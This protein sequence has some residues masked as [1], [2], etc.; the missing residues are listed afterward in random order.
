MKS[1]QNVPLTINA[2]PLTSVLARPRFLQTGY[3]EL[4]RKEVAVTC[5]PYG[6]TSAHNIDYN[7]DHDGDDSS[8]SRLILCDAVSSRSLCIFRGHLTL[9]FSFFIVP[10]WM[11]SI[12]ST[13]HTSAI[14][15]Y[16]P[17]NPCRQTKQ[18]HVGAP[19]ELKAHLKF[20]PLSEPGWLRVVTNRT[21]RV[22][23]PFVSGFHLPCPDNG[24]LRNTETTYDPVT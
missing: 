23:A 2:V 18:T 20:P 6:L 1:D 14:R 10:A 4:W 15:S 22:F 24:A 13:G 11:S 8:S 21:G 5:L 9:C 19:N 12:P 7:I 16:N 3:L 17:E